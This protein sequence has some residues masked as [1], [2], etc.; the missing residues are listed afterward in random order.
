[1]PG[2]K[3]HSGFTPHMQQES[4]LP[5][6]AKRKKSGH[7]GARKGAG[8]K[9]GSVNKGCVT[10]ALLTRQLEAAERREQALLKQVSK[11]TDQIGCVIENKF[12]SVRITPEQMP[13]PSG[14]TF[15]VEQ[16]MDV[17]AHDDSDF[18]STVKEMTH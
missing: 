13:E 18:I 1:M 16:L 7:G 12:D 11:L 17:H 4:K 6:K 10:C 5:S 2:S 3:R 9:P 15:P 8:R 14:P